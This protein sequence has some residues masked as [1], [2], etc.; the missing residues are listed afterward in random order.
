MASTISAGTTSG[1]ALNMAGD[2]TGILQLQTNGTTTAVTIDASQNVGIGTASPT[3]LLSLN[4]PAST[5]KGMTIDNA[6]NAVAGFTANAATGE[7]RIGG[8]R[9]AGWFPTFY[10]NNT[11]AMRIDTAGSLLV[12]TT[13]YGGVGV[14]IASPVSGG[15]Y[16]ANSGTG[17]ANN[18]RFANANGVIGSIQTSG[19]AT[20]YNT[21]SDY[22]LK[23]DI[24]PMTGALTTVSQLKPVTYKWKADGSAGQGF[25]AHEL[26]A[27]VP[28]CVSG[29]KDAVDEDGKPVHQGID[30]S[31][32]V[33][34]LT[35]A[36]QELNAKVTALEAQLGAK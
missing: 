30:T 32:L 18:V 7:I 19:S 36:I 27:I 11:E 12:G 14:G 20:V 28:D 17:F 10:Y 23:K 2:T 29:E 34:T 15:I 5:T 8:I 3:N 21:S 6:G 33:A 16:I 26:Q 9:N 35:A 1:T 31:F 4:L 25:I 24:L 13:T 22:R